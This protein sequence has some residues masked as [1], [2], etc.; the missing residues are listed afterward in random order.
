MTTGTTTVNAAVE[1]FSRS[2]L[3]LEDLR[4]IHFVTIFPRVF[5]SGQEFDSLLFGICDE[6]TTCMLCRVRTTNELMLS[7]HVVF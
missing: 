3:S 6:F 5:Q 2:E 4:G 7:A 1:K